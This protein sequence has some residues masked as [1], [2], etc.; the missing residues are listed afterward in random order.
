MNHYNIIKYYLYQIK[1]NN[2]Y[3]LIAIKFTILFFAY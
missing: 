3:H 1:K 2:Y